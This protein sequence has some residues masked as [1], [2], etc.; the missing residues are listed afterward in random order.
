MSNTAR[1]DDIDEF[2]TSVR[3]LISQKEQQ[4][5]KAAER[6]VLQPDQRVSADL[7]DDAQDT[8]I[9]SETHVAAETNNVLLLEAEHANG[10]E[11]LEATIAEL[12]AAVTAQSGDWEA[13]DGEEFVEAAWAASAFDAPKAKSDEAAAQSPNDVPAATQEPVGQAKDASMADEL[14]ATVMANVTAGLDTE[15]LRALVIATVY[16]EL[17][18]ELGERIT[19]NVRKLVRREINRVLANYDIGPD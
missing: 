7:E 11:G 9:D 16:E 18:G 12:E 2:L 5:T 6:L 8:Q 1:T 17:G 4:K 14:E 10:R 3:S 13:D 15:A 19:Q